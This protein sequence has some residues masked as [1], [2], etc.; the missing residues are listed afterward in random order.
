MTRSGSTIPMATS[1]VALHCV[2]LALRP[3][4]GIKTCSDAS[5]AKAAIEGEPHRHGRDLLP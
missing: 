5:L 1:F 2:N 3:S 4:G